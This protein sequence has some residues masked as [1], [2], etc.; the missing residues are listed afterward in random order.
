MR[1][2]LFV[3]MHAFVG[4]TAPEPAMQMLVLPM[5]VLQPVWQQFSTRTVQK[6]GSPMALQYPGPPMFRRWAEA[7]RRSGEDASF[8]V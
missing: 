8:D 6:L 1:L 5:A 2:A 3:P 4:A 7:P